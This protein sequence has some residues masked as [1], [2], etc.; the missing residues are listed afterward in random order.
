MSSRHRR[1]RRALGRET[2]TAA[3]VH[4]PAERQRCNRPISPLRRAPHLDAATGVQINM[5]KTGDYA[6]K[7]LV[8]MTNAEIN[9]LTPDR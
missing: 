1:Q 6:R 8:D 5:Q 9:T 4:T 7:R 3:L 2:A